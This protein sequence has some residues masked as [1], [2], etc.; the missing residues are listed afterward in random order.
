[1]VNNAFTTPE[2]NPLN[3]ISVVGEE[4]FTVYGQVQCHFLYI[5]KKKRKEKK[6][7][8]DIW[9]K[10]L[11]YCVVTTYFFI[12]INT[13]KVEGVHMSTSCFFKH[14]FLPSLVCCVQC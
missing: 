13:P 12:L 5:V 7:I 8:Y 11:I 14:S 9:Q 10:M 2:N 6:Y 3:S 4:F 1:M